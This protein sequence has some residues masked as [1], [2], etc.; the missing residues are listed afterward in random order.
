MK[1]PSRRHLLAALDEVQGLVGRARAEYE[2]DRAPDRANKLAETFDAA[3]RL[4][5]A[6]RG[7]DAPLTTKVR[8]RLLAE[9]TTPLPPPQR[10]KEE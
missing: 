3:F 6:A 4:C 1:K 2:N 8:T 5:V 9:L 7:F 10:P